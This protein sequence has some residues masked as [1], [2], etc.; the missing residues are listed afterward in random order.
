MS[1]DPCPHLTPQEE[2]GTPLVCSLNAASLS[3][4][5]CMNPVLL[6]ITRSSGSGGLLPSTWPPVTSSVFASAPRPQPSLARSA[7]GFTLKNPSCSG[8]GQAG[9]VYLLLSLISFV[10]D[11][12]QVPGEDRHIRVYYSFLALGLPARSIS[13]GCCQPH[14]IN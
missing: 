4:G 10:G 9:L 7:R 12:R 14:T 6:P 5:I 8:Q 13:P 1:P 3:S 11:E 2:T